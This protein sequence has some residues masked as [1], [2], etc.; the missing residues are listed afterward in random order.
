MTKMQMIFGLISGL[1]F[2]APFFFWGFIR[3]WDKQNRKVVSWHKAAIL[4]GFIIGAFLFTLFLLL[5]IF[6]HN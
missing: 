2:V 4:F 6:I 1:M 3:F 5:A